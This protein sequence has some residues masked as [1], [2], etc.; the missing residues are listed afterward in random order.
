MFLP[1]TVEAFEDPIS[2]PPIM[3]LGFSWIELVVLPVVGRDMLRQDRCK[4]YSFR[5]LSAGGLP[6]VRRREM[7]DVDPRQVCYVS[8]SV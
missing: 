2:L 3:T 7:F 5:N 6:N 4:N 8:G 1:G